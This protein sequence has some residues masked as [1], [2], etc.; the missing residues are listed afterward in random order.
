MQ[1]GGTTGC[2][3]RSFR[4]SSLLKC[5][6]YRVRTQMQVGKTSDLYPARLKNHFSLTLIYCCCQFTARGLYKVIKH[7]DYTCFCVK[8]V[9]ARVGTLA[10]FFLLHT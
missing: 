3:H 9:R 6:V 1:T 4:L 5:K 10:L 2:A 7:D 8:R